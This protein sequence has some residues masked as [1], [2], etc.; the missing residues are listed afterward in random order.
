MAPSEEDSLYGSSD[1]YQAVNDWSG[2]YEVQTPQAAPHVPQQAGFYETGASYDFGSSHEQSAPASTYTDATARQPVM[3]QSYYESVYASYAV[4]PDPQP[5]FYAQPQYEQQP[6]AHYQQP[7]AQYDQYEAVQYQ[8]AQYTQP[9]HE[10][11]NFHHPEFDTGQFEAIYEEPG[12]TEASYDLLPDGEGA[13]DSYDGEGYGDAD[14]LDYEYAGYDDT[15]DDLDGD[16]R[17]GYSG[18]DGDDLGQDDFDDEPAPIRSRGR[19]A[20]S[21]SA[22]AVDVA[23]KAPR[24]APGGA[25]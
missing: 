24:P 12:S 21:R 23:E 15:D 19:A 5:E 2:V 18:Y 7:Q 20:F 16:Y 3:D 17:D 13:Y 14:Y 6:Q 4:Q 11:H 25:G 10:Q 1:S 9:Q 8:P 22:A